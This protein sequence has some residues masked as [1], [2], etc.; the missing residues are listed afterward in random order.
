M[1]FFY[2][3]AALLREIFFRKCTFCTTIL[4]HFSVYSFKVCQCFRSLNGEEP[5]RRVLD[6]QFA[7]S[8][9]YQS[10]HESADFKLLE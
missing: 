6:A 1:S 8:S 9:V 4:T 7:I 2:F 5:P 3:L 10:D